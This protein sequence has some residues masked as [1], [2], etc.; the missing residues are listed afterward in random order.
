LGVGCGV[1]NPTPEISTVTKPPEP[2]GEAKTQ[3][4]VAPVKKKYNRKKK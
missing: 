4:F 2:I 1:K 3:R